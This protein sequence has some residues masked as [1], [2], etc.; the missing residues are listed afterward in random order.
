MMKN[1]LYEVNYE[2]KDGSL[3]DLNNYKK[4]NNVYVVG[5]TN[6]GKS[7]MINKIL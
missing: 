6:S 4:S 5:F 2:F 7:T 1:E 3:L